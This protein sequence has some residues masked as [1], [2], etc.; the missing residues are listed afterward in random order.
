MRPLRPVILAALALVSVTARSFAQTPPLTPDVPAHFDAVAATSD[1]AKR[2]AMIP[3][4]DGVKLYTVIVIPKGAA[5]A[6]MI[7]TRTP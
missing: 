1:Y 5:H 6:P 4:R 7:L 3:M 2:V